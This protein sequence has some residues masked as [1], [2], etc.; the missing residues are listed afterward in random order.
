M[1]NTCSQPPPLSPRTCT[2]DQQ[3]Y[4][5]ACS[6][7][8]ERPAEGGGGEVGQD[9]RDKVQQDGGGGEELLEGKHLLFISI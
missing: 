4:C 8:L 1:D 9:T 3:L 7:L 2:L 5:Q 6:Q